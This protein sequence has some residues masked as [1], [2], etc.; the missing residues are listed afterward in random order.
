LEQKP[1]P[2]EVGPKERRMKYLM[3]VLVAAVLF[4][5]AG[6]GGQGEAAPPLE[7]TSWELRA[8]LPARGAGEAMRPA[9]PRLYTVFFGADGHAALRV[10]CNRATG[11]WTATPDGGL[12]FGMLASTRALCPP[13]SEGERVLR[14]L[15]RVRSYGIRDGVLVMPLP[16]DGEIYEWTPAQP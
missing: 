5:C 15:A 9:D 8:I 6:R 1:G 4:G 16:Q 2:G 12:Q 11:T 10:D 3:C 7:G 13:Q 14:D